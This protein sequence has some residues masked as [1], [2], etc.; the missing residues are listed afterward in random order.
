VSFDLSTHPHFIPWTDPESGG[1][2][3]IL[4]ERVAPLQQSLYFTNPSVSDDECWLWFYVAFPPAQYKL[5]ASASL[6]PAAP[7]IRYFPASAFSSASPMVAPEK[8][9]NIISRQ[10]FPVYGRNPYHLDPRPQF[11][12]QDSWVVHTTT[13]RGLV[14]VALTPTEPLKAQLA[15]R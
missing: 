2:S 13:V 4:N 6:D 3:F 10:P 8:E 7:F 9:T 11:S 5:L 14:D 15:L 12:P 1:V